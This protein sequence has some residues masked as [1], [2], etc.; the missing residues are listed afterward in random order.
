M[1]VTKSLQG[2]PRRLK[3][4]LFHQFHNSQ[5]RLS[6]KM[7][8]P[9]SPDSWRSPISQETIFRAMS[10]CPK[11]LAI[12]W[13]PILQQQVPKPADLLEWFRDMPP[14]NMEHNFGV[15]TASI[16]TEEV[17]LAIRKLHRSKACRPDQT[18]CQTTSILTMLTSWHQ[19]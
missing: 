14:N 19:C 5:K 16:T 6:I 13:K 15:L 18:V 11:N 2:S 9:P 10:S 4:N 12:D 17:Q 8:S 3:Q 1:N 7:A